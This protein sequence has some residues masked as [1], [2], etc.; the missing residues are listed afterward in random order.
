M[1]YNMVEKLPAQ[2]QMFYVDTDRKVTLGVLCDGMGGMG[3]G[4]L[5]S[6]LAVQNFAEA[7][8][9]TG[10]FQTMWPQRLLM[11]LY[12]ANASLAYLKDAMP[13]VKRD[14]GCTL[15]AVVIADD[16]LHFLSVGDSPIF[17]YRRETNS[18]G[19]TSY[20]EYRLNVPHES[21]YELD[22]NGQYATVDDAG[23][24]V[25]LTPE[26]VETK[27]QD[28]ACNPSRYKVML[29]SA[30]IGREIQ[31]ICQ[32]G[33]SNAVDVQVGDIIVVASDGYEK[34]LPST[35]RESTIFNYSEHS[36][37]QTAQELIRAV[38]EKGVAEQDNASCL[39]FK[40]MP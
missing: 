2:V 4:A 18:Y 8:A 11:S 14:S 6:T 24:S 15:S 1:A 37:E 3:N 5:C 12:A 26:E 38:E 32:S 22:A 29:S 34:T 20:K 40:V 31:Q 35:L 10:S 27:R 25:P 19:H 33:K 28:I 7:F 13:S 21:Y 16:V 39:V 23:Y 30:V 17:L 9:E 36:P